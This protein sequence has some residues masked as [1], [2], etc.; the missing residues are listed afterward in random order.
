MFHTRLA[1]ALSCLSG[2]A[3]A[4]APNATMGRQ[5]A[6]EYCSACHMIE[7]GGPFKQ[8]PPSFAAIAVY[9][10]PD[11]IRARIVQPIHADM[12]RYSD[13]MIGGNID[14]MVAYIASLEK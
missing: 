11:Q 8:E 4:D 14:D 2:I 12:P 10:S 13:Y 5:I 1:I 6:E 9:R 7:P 3:L